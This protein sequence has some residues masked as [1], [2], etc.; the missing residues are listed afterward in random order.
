M[1]KNLLIIRNFASKVNADTYNLQEIGLG[2]ALVRKGFNCDVVYFNGDAPTEIEQIYQVDG[3]VLRVI[4]MKAKKIF[5]NGI[6]SEV[7]KRGFLKRYKYVMS[8]EY[9]QLMTYLLS[10]V[11]PEK[12]LIYHG[13]YKYDDKKLIQQVYDLMC[14]PRIRKVTNCFVKSDL[15]KKYLIEKK[16]N[17]ITVGVG[18]DTDNLIKSKE[19]NKEV[20]SKL[21]KAHGTKNLLYIGVLEERR[22][23]SFLLRIF[24]LV[25]E[26]HDDAR[27]IIVGNGTEEDKRVYM[28]Y[29]EEHGLEDKI[30]YFERVEQK[31]LWQ[32]YKVSDLMLFPTTYDIF[33]MVL[34]ESFY[35]QVPIISSL[36]GG[37]STLINNYV[38]GIIIETFDEELWLKE[39]NKV[40]LD[41]AFRERLKTNQIVTSKEFTWDNVAAK[42]LDNLA[43]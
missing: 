2:K 25:E 33:G 16:L 39:I 6:Y 15:A 41:E 29:I 12:L 22:N 23:I 4:K 43:F 20:E 21:S 10:I 42:L 24:K 40:L 7:F 30:I 3:N 34:L 8:T 9:H 26:Q 32:I 27:L 31:N 13:P 18:L 11:C 36:N 5:S 37:S 1:E 17:C 28:R 14:L 35:F 19:I 38:N